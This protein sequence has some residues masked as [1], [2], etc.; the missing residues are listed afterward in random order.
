[1]SH[2]C[3]GEDTEQGFGEIWEEGKAHPSSPHQVS[4]QSHSFSGM[5]LVW[6]KD[7]ALGGS[8]SL[9]KGA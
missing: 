3:R 9:G 1:M 2:T 8:K 5:G 6:G 4:K 7:C